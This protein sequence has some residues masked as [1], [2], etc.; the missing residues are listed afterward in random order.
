MKYVICIH[1]IGNYEKYINLSNFK[2]PVDIDAYLFV[3]EISQK[4]KLIFEK[5]KWNVVILNSSLFNNTEF[6]K[7]FRIMSKYCKFQIHKYFCENNITY[8]FLI[9]HD[10]NIK[11][12]YNK[13]KLFHKSHNFSNIFKRWPHINLID[14]NDKYKNNIIFWEIDDMLTNRQHYVRTSRTNVLEWRDFLESSNY[15]NNDY[16]ESNIYII[17]LQ[18][19]LI[20][21]SF[22]IVYDKCNQIQRDQFI[23]PWSFQ[24]NSVNITVVDQRDFIKHLKYKYVNTRLKR[25]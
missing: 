14:K 7:K 18:D 19:P 25:N 10:F 8:D 20:S 1:N 23:L 4:I 9:Y 21:K 12:N 6:V 22:D 16:Y 24:Q 2:K 11:I 5:M 17:S 15:E 13:I 3:D